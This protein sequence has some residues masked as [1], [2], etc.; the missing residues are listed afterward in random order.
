MAEKKLKRQAPVRG[1]DAE[2]DVIVVGSGYAG[3][4]AAIEAHDAGSAVAILEKR[5][6]IGG[7][8]IIA[9]GV[10]NAVDQ[11]RQKPMGIDDSIELHYEQTLSGG[12]FRGEP[13]KVRYLVEHALDGWTW[14]EGMGVELVE[15][16]QGYGAMWPRCHRPKYKGKFAG[17]AIVAALA[18]QVKARKIPLLMEHRVTGVH[19]PWSKERSTGL[20]VEVRGKTLRLKARNG[21]VLAS[22]GFCADVE[23][24]T[25]HDPRFDARFGTT[26]HPESTGE[27]IRMAQDCGADVVG[28]DF[29]QSIGPTG[30]DARFVKPPAGTVSLLKGLA[31]RIGGVTVDQCIYA[32]LR[33]KRIIAADARRDQITETVMRTPEKVCVVVC[34]E[35]SRITASYGVTPLEKIEQIMA[36]HPRELYRADTIRELAVKMG[37]PDPAVLEETVARYNA[38]VDAK[39]DPEFGQMARNLIWKCEKPPF[40]AATASPALHYM[41]G[42]IRTEGASTRVLDR[43]G[44]VI[45]RLFVAGEVMGGVH[46]TNRLGGNATAECVVFGRLAG[47]EAAGA[48]RPVASR[49]QK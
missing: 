17:A 47:R 13:V 11:E 41:C 48:Q 14:L 8:S 18:D 27:I 16:F 19:G 40:W 38:C 43:W 12:D 28:M 20:S 36:Q 21:I 29:I 2:W 25:H 45:P 9:G 35:Q 39:S 31:M 24:R 6:I 4:S 23:M 34:D 15:L 1:W 22:G 49:I 44:R 30:R 10:Y 32:D 42:G 33:G 37:M 26:C 3:L 5:R 7:N 46:G